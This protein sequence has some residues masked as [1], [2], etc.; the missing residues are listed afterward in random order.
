MTYLVLIALTEQKVLV[1]RL[2]LINTVIVNSRERHRIFTQ[3]VRGCHKSCIIPELVIGLDLSN[4]G[5]MGLSRVLLER[6][7]Q[8]NSSNAVAKEVVYFED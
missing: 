8:K 2:K 7:R 4:E 5:L 3:I 6:G 1:D